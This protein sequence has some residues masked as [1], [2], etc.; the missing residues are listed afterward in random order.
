MTY[1]PALI[2]PISM[3]PLIKGDPYHLALAHL[4]LNEDYGPEYQA[5]FAEESRNGSFVVLDNGAHELGQGLPPHVLSELADE[6]GASEIVLPDRLFWGDDTAELSQA[7][8]DD[9]MRHYEG[10]NMGY[11]G[12]PHGRTIYE[13]V[14]CMKY[15]I[16]MGVTSIGI[17]KDYEVWEGGM[18]FLASLVPDHTPIHLLGFGREPERL[19]AD[20]IFKANLRGS[21][22]GKPIIL[23]MANKVFNRRWPLYTKRPHNY[24]DLPFTPED[25]GLY[26]RLKL[27]I[28]AYYDHYGIRNVNVEEKLHR[29]DWSFSTFKNDRFHGIPNE[30]RL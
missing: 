19:W 18:M 13:W 3:L 17:S 2:P 26:N 4:A 10:N 23:A 12:V 24:F 20:Q 16:E 29:L 27:N 7:A 25:E 1:P 30:N 6:M 21:D 28:T 9:F 15:L 22:S 5:F 11:M 8:L 14:K